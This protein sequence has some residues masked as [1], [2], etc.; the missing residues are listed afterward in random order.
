MK[1]KI[2]LIT[3]VSR[4]LG[5]ALAAAALARG[6]VVVGTTR[7]GATPSGLAS[8]RLSV[9][10]LEITDRAQS[11]RVVAEAHSLH[12]RLDVVVN[13]AGYGLLGSIEASTPE[14]AEHLFAV[15]FFGPLNVIQAAL[16]L[17]R[18]Q[19]SGHIVNLSSVATL[20]PMAGS[21]L[22]AAAKSA[23][24]GLSQS[25]A[26]EAAP[27]GIWVTAVEPGAFRTDFLAKTS[28]RRSARTIDD[29]AATSGRAVD[30]LLTK[31]GTQLG[32]P[33]RGAAAIVEAVYADE[34]PQNLV[35]GSDAI[36][37]TR[38]RLARFEDD[39]ARW[40]SVGL[41]TDFAA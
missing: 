32:D 19:R 24:E 30:G 13:N 11:R 20:A 23:I 36:Q 33:A 8:D 17:L 2:W 39:L 22:Y 5:A 28:I 9:L 31:H 29:Y 3:G 15:N 41:G 25:L 18:A 37:R 38:A 21:G 1:P 12:G 40:E 14:E 7:D 4:G 35:L 27:S 34:P 26:Q 10:P 6:D 16:P